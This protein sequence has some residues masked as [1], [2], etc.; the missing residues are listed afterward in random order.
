MSIDRQA[1]VAYGV[2]MIP[3]SPDDW[4]KA[5]SDAGD[6]G[7]FAYM[8]GDNCTGNSVGI[9]ICI[10]GYVKWLDDDHVGATMLCEAPTHKLLEVFEKHYIGLQVGWHACYCVS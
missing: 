7:L 4:D 10:P 6:L 2:H 8:T 5:E 9:M 3:S 1:F